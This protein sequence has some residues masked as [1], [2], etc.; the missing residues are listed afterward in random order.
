MT[1]KSP[2]RACDDVDE[3]ALSYAEVKALC[4]GNPLIAEKMNLEI[5][6]SRL[7]ILRGD[8]QSDIYRLQ[9]SITQAFPMQIER[10]KASIANYKVDMAMVAANTHKGD[11]GISPM[12]IGGRVYTDRAEAGEAL[13]LARKS[14]RGV[15]P[16]TVGSYRGLQ[17]QI[18]FDSFYKEYKLHLK[19]SN[20]QT[21]A[22]GD[23]AGNIMRLDN[24]IDKMAESL[25]RV[26]ERL[27]NLLEQMEA[28]KLAIQKPFPQEAVYQEKVT[29]LAELDAALNVDDR[30]VTSI[31]EQLVADK[32]RITPGRGR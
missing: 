15:G 20:T 7:K 5:E 28:A 17:M 27:E 2:V 18:S 29:K 24:A 10:A 13:L 9:D 19:G 32:S 12:T 14:L 4:A 25:Q 6:V 23:S 21:L 8:Y 16:E 30:E 26:G 3:S 1:S 11:E 31:K 22:M